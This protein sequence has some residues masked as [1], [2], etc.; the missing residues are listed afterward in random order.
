MGHF[1]RLSDHVTARSRKHE[2]TQPQDEGSLANNMHIW[3]VILLAA[4]NGVR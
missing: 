3:S 4:I 2:T 1:M